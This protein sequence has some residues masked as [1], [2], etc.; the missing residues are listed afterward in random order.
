MTKRK[1]DEEFK[2]EIY[3]LVKDEYVFLE[4]YQGALNKIKVKHNTCGNVYDVMP[5]KFLIGSRC[6]YCVYKDRRK[7]DEEFKQEVYDLVGD[8][9]V[10]LD[11]YVNNRTKLKVKHKTCGNVYEVKPSNFLTGYRCPYC[12]GNANKT[13]K[14]FKQE[15]YSLVGDTYVFLDTYVNNYTKLKVKHK[16]CGNV[17]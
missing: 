17:Y 3:S 16:T 6:P 12:Y 1:T 8:E 13:D 9:Y 7:T 4:P 15:I 11:T 14:Q 10:F 2:Q 5:N